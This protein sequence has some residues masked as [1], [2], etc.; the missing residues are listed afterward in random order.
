MTQLTGTDRITVDVFPF[1]FFFP[2]KL[3]C[4][5][6]NVEDYKIDI[7]VTGYIQVS[8]LYYH[9]GGERELEHSLALEASFHSNPN[10]PQR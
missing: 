6:T 2:F 8:S 9:P 3:G 5:K 4:Y 10:L 1:N 7:L